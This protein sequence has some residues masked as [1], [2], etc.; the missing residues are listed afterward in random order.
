V[1]GQHLCVLTAPLRV[2]GQGS[3]QILGAVGARRSDGTEK[4]NAEVSDVSSV[5]LK[6]MKR[7]D[8]TG[9]SRTLQNQMRIFICSSMP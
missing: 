2:A 1:S 7:R 3:S 9:H 6:G 5:F 8:L 4:R